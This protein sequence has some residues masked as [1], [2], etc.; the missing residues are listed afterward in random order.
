VVG[1]TYRERNIKYLISLIFI[2]IF[3]VTI[4][5]YL[6]SLGNF[7]PEEMNREYS[8]LNI[9]VFSALSITSIYSFLS[10]ITYLFLEF[11]LKKERAEFLSAKFSILVTVGIFLIF[12]LN[13]LHILDIYWGVGILVILIFI[14]FVI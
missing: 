2:L 6:L 12:L 8:V 9:S 5:L 10:L 1:K 14:S 4:L 11:I 13:F 7:L 3:S